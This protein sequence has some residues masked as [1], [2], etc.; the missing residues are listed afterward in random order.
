MA[1]GSSDKGYVLTDVINP[2][3]FYNV[4]MRNKDKFSPQDQF[5][6]L[7]FLDKLSDS[8]DFELVC[9]TKLSSVHYTRKRVGSLARAIDCPYPEEI[10]LDENL[11]LIPVIKEGQDISWILKVGTIVI[12]DKLTSND[13][14]K[15]C[16]DINYAFT[17]RK[18]RGEDK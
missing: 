10:K 18:Q 11:K 3:E 1:S 9:K 6:I 13:A 14:L 5:T 4:L 7:R 17:I 2:V 16:K 12:V 15:V 8:Q